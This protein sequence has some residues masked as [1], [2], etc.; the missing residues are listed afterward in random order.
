MPLFKTKTSQNVLAKEGYMRATSKSRMPHKL[1][2]QER[3]AAAAAAMLP[4]EAFYSWGTFIHI[5]SRV[6]HTEQWDERHTQR[7][8]GTKA[9][10]HQTCDKQGTV[11]AFNCT[12]PVQ[13]SR[14]PVCPASFSKASPKNRPTIR[15]FQA[16]SLNLPVHRFGRKYWRN[17]KGCPSSILT[18]FLLSPAKKPFSLSVYCPI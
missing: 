13:S 11:P 5:L 2:E 7:F 15:P 17:D 8:H 1:K 3:D 18:A 6:P 14:S 9:G 4:P 16:F 12:T 10:A